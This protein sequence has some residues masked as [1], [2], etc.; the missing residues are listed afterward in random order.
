MSN[1]RRLLLLGCVPALTL[2]CAGRPTPVR[3][4]PAS[5]VM[6]QWLATSVLSS[7][8]APEAA[9]SVNPYAPTRLA[10]AA[11]YSWQSEK[12]AECEPQSALSGAD[13][14]RRSTRWLAAL[15]ESTSE[16]TDQARPISADFVVAGLRPAIH[17]CFSRWLDSK[18]DAQGSV[19]LALELGCAGEVEA[20]S[21]ENRGVD[22]ST[23]TCLFSALAPARFA[24]P[25]GGHATVLVPVVFK[26][27]AR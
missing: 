12:P 13:L 25:A 11:V 24:P 14:E 17:H 26:N 6:P 7:T 9:I 5:S 4:Q 8:P 23:L 2:S 3:S 20:I 22:E 21:A 16:S 18:L 15:S 27:A 10:G 1:S 19:R